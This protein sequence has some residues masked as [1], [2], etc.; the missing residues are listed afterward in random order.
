MEY[1]KVDFYLDA[2]LKALLMKCPA[3]TFVGNILT[4]IA[5]YLILVFSGRFENKSFQ[6][7]S[8]TNSLN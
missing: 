4:V 3:L 6:I 7:I 5:V 8:R 1:D 2:G